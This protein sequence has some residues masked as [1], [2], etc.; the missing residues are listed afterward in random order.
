MELGMVLSEA[1]AYVIYGYAASF[2][3]AF[4]WFAVTEL[5]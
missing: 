5:L 4:T 3:C 1:I 2:A